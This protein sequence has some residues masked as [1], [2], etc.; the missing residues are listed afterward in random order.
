MQ[1]IIKGTIFE[2]QII[3]ALNNILALNPEFRLVNNIEVYSHRFK[4]YTQIDHLLL[5]SGGIYCIEA[6][7]F[8]SSLEGSFND[9]KWVGTSGKYS[10]EIFNPI[11]QNYAHIRAFNNVL[12]RDK[13]PTLPIENYVIVNDK[14]SI[15]S[16]SDNVLN[17]SEFVRVVRRDLR[18]RRINLN[19]AKALV[20]HVA[21]KKEG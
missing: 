21:T 13:L 17:L 11:F 1:P 8:H 20:L 7:G 9:D 14:C 16:T 18:R 12:R 10:Q 2:T 19:E 3:I 15:K 4:R 5:T 6:K